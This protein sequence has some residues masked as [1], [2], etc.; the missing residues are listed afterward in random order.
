MALR[1]R[2]H[3][4]LQLA[5]WSLVLALLA[6]GL[7]A[8]TTS[9][10]DGVT[11]AGLAPGS[12][13][14][15]YPLLNFEH[16]N[17]FSG[18][19]NPSVQ[20]YHIGGRG[21]AG[22]DLVWNLQ[23]VWRAKKEGVSTSPIVVVDPYPQSYPVESPTVD[24]LEVAGVVYSRTGIEFTSCSTGSEPGSSVTRVIFRTPTGTEIELIDQA[25]SASVYQI[26]NACTSP[27]STY[28]A[29]RGTVFRS[30]DGSE[31]SFV[32]DSNVLEQMNP[33]FGEGDA[34]LSGYLVFPNGVTYRIDNS[35]VT[36][37]RDTNG[38]KTTF[39]YS[40]S[41]FLDVTW[42]LK[43]PAATTI[44]DSDNRTIT[45]N[46]HDSSCGTYC[47]SINYPG[48]NGAAR[49]IMIELTNLSSGLLLGG[50]SVQTIA[51]LFPTSNAYGGSSTTFDPVLPSAIIFPDNF[52]YDFGYDTYGEVTEVS[53]AQGGAV[54]YT[55]GDGNN[56]SSS[57][58]E[59]TATGSSA[60]MIYRRLQKRTEY[61][62]G[63]GSNWTAQTDYTVSYA[64][65]QTVD[66]D[67]T[68]SSSS[69]V[70]GQTV[71]TMDGSP[72]DALNLSG[73]GCNAWNEGAEVETQ[74]GSPILRTVKNTLQ[75]QSGCMNSPKIS[76]VQTINDAGQV[77]QVAYTYDV[78]NNVTQET[79]Y[80][81]GNGGPG[82]ALRTIATYYLWANNSSY[83]SP[84]VNLVKAPSS[85]YV[86]AGTGGGAALASRQ[87]SYDLSGTVS[88][89]PDSASV[90]GHDSGYLTAGVATRANVSTYQ[91]F[92]NTASSEATYQMK[93]DSLG[94][95]LS[96]Q[97]P[98]GNTTTFSYADAF[99]DGI[100]RTTYG[101]LTATTN[102]LN[103]TT[104]QQYD[105]SS[106]S[107]TGYTDLNGALTAYNQRFA[108]KQLRDGPAGDD[109]ARRDPAEGGD[110]FQLPEPERH[111][112]AAGPDDDGRRQADVLRNSRRLW[113]IGGERP[114]QRDELAGGDLHE[115]GC[116]GESALRH[117][118]VP[119]E[120]QPGL[121]EWG[122]G[123]RPQ[124]E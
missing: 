7:H 60:V 57:G 20:L 63:A 62:N 124:Y 82:A 103:Q 85:V 71:H 115:P 95:L 65:S 98:L 73:T 13:A 89:E 80:G 87:W 81:F 46:Y 16:Y 102:A 37:I 84:T 94:N 75:A 97:D 26:P 56:G 110:Q 114:V 101:Y 27:Q 96:A 93:Y 54:E 107:I 40:A 51:S 15:S 3:Q 31:I 48:V 30:T 90:P 2:F 8:Q 72:L 6:P 47:A 5:V 44:T 123:H 35:T 59:G 18:G 91:E 92:V 106:G 21:N 42:Y 76:T 111:Y 24:G 50:G 32:A 70:V 25:T 109:H 69:Q 68:Y 100:S 45:I 43:V 38:N 64:G 23:Q 49:K 74:Y 88:D 77:S 34:K 120:R 33:A 28:N 17:P 41:D 79:D 66:T 105:Y 122:F 108:R 58:F 61:A 104:S 10:Y 86:Y 12:P 78:Y 119:G 121:P 39:A 53:V 9:V 116:A 113:E 52:Q 117:R 55:Y 99:S 4:S 36:Y 29:G 11:P 14:S 83:A 19:L 1:L 112:H 67:V 118:A 22:F